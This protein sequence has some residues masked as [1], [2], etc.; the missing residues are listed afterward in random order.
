MN[1]ITNSSESL[2]QALLSLSSQTQPTS[3]NDDSN[4]LLEAFAAASD[5]L[6]LSGAQ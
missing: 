1:P 2:A 5:T 3:A 6:T 4:Q